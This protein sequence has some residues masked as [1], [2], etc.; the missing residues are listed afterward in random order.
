[1]FGMVE[2]SSNK[3]ILYPV[4][5]RKGKTLLPIIKRHVTVGT[6]ILSN[7]WR[8]YDSLND[9]GYSHFNVIHTE[10]MSIKM[11]KLEKLDLSLRIKWR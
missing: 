9:E 6:D 1:M 3:I 2:V 11:W 5:N 7:S 4:K 10:N 8:P